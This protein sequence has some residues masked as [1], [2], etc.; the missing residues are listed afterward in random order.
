MSDTP[1]ASKSDK[2][3]QRDVLE[4]H[5]CIYYYDVATGLITL[6]SDCP[7]GS[8][9]CP[10]RLGSQVTVPGQG[11]A[12]LP[13][14][15]GYPSAPQTLHIHFSST[16]SILYMYERR[17]EGGFCYPGQLRFAP[18]TGNY[19][20][21][22]LDTFP[23]MGPPLSYPLPTQPDDPYYVALATVSYVERPSS[24]DPKILA[25]FIR[26]EIRCDKTAPHQPAHVIPAQRN[27]TEF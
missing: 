20:H 23:S 5:Y 25:P 26:M 8:G 24:V 9:H 27:S 6:D 10:P 16:T 11:P 15:K 3:I 19:P 1:S 2:P 4:I 13:C 22:N 21:T 18:P 12:N 17:F 14:S 7:K